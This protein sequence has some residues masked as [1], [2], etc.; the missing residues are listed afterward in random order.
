MPKRKEPETKAGRVSA[1]DVISH[2]NKKVGHEVAHSLK[3][4]NPSDV[5]GWIPTG[6]TWLDGIIARGMWAGIPIGK[7][8]SIAGLESC[9]TKDTKIKVIL[10]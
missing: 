5:V 3:D 4:E 6:A 1:R 9:V 8:S 7:I 2:I 10:E